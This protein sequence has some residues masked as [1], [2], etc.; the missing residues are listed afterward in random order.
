MFLDPT[1]F[2]ITQSKEMGLWPPSD[3]VA[4]GVWPYINRLKETNLRIL[5]VGVM[6]GENAMFLLEKDTGNKIKKVYGVVSYDPEHKKDFNNYEE[7][8]KTNTNGVDR[9]S[10]AYIDQSCHVVCIHA[11]SDLNYNLE[12][13]YAAVK[14][15]GIFCGNEHHLPRVK[16]SLSAFRRKNKIGTPIMVSNG[17]WFWYKR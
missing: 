12:K 2:S 4:H 15:N 11:Y 14:S 7:V 1:L 8:L 3:L 16:E 9:I 10:L 13:Y 6:K 17:C 5:D